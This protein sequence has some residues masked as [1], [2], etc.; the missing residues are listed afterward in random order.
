MTNLIQTLKH[1]PSRILIVVIPFLLMGMVE[2]LERGTYEELHKWVMSHPLSMVLAYFVVGTMYLFLIA[3]T[4]RS[5]LS[6]WMLCAILLPL[7]AISGSKLKAIGAPY[8]PWDLVFNN[9]IV[10]YKAFLQGYLN[11]RIIG[12]VA[13]FLAIIALLFHLTL[14]HRRIHFTWIERS[15]YAVIAIIMATSLY[16]DKPIPFMNLYGIYTVPWDQTI[17]YDENGYLYSS[18]QMLGFLKVAK[19]DG[20]SKKAVTSILEQI[21]E[22]KAANDKKPNIIVML[23]EAFWD[24]TIMKNITFSRDPIPNLHQLQKTFTSG[25]MLSPQFGGSTA[26]V[27]FEVLSSNS[28]RFFGKSPDKILPYIEYMNHGVDSLASITT[29]QGYT[30]TSINPFFS[31]F[32]DSRKVYK[33]FGFSRFIASEFF[34][35]DFEGP[36]YADRAVVKK[37]IEETEKS[38]GPDFI[39]ANT[40]ENHHPFKPGK[41][42]K[43]TIEVKGDITPE[44]KGIL[45]TY[46]QGI[47]GTDKALQSLID[48][49][50]NKSEPTIILF[51]GDHLPFFEENYKVYRDAKYVLPDDPDLYTKTHYTPFLIWNNFLPA[52]QEKKDLK[53]SPSFLGPKVLQMAGVQGSYYTDYLYALSQKIP[54]IPPN[55]MW[56]KYQIKESDLSDYMK[57]QY[58]NLFGGRYG[59]EAKGFKDSIVQP[60]YTLGYGDPVI[61]KVIQSDKKLQVV[62]KPFYSS[63]NVYIDGVAF[64][65]NFDGEDTLYVDLAENPPLE[66]GKPHQV[67]VRIYDDKK[68][69]IG[70]SNLYPLP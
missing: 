26:N 19:P 50:S 69:K 42:I 67:E 51:F 10:E 23:G 4:G 39:F 54:V 8:Y 6:F 40:M 37:I 17:T 55:E 45:E 46:A 27:E 64:K 14:L 56:D 65:S 20:Y 15:I 53:I 44:S 1:V 47:S 2:Y 58:D 5:R 30:A 49:Y 7:G 32:F 59:Y 3:L 38:K 41:F 60:G 11:F 29:R 66:A 24:P 68:M 31:Y 25:W 48:Y 36:N 28:M 21:P 35:N 33:H 16:T 13:I 12:T 34:P 63:C 9:Q 22:Q 62:G 52:D 57:L 70:Q 43:N 18:V 61:T